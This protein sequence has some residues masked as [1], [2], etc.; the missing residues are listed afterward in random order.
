MEGNHFCFYEE[1]ERLPE[2]ERDSF[3]MTRKNIYGIKERKAIT[4]YLYFYAHELGISHFGECYYR[5]MSEVSRV[6]WNETEE[7]GK[8]LG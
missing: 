3:V 4:P 5:Y 1:D 2:G 6:D 8:L 7:F